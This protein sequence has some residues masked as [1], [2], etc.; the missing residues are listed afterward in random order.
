[1]YM[2]DRWRVGYAAL[3]LA[4]VLAGCG[5]SQSGQQGATAN[6]S[7]G[8]TDSAAASVAASEAPAGTTPPEESPR[9]DISP[10]ASVAPDASSSASDSPTVAPAGAASAEAQATAA[11]QQPSP[12]TFD[13]QRITLALE[14]AA[15]GLDRPLF[16]THAGDGSGRAFVVEKGGAIRTLAD[17]QL[18]LDISDR[19]NARSSEQGLLGLAFHPR[20]PENGQ[21]FVYYTDR[22]GDE[23]VSR[24]GLAADGR[25]DPA[26]EKIILRQEDPAA[27]HNGGMITFGQDGML[28]IGLGDGGGAND[29]F[30]NGQNR[31]TFLGKLLRID[32]DQGD[33]YAVP[34]DNP[35]VN[36]S[37]TRPEIW[38]Y[39]LRNPWRFSFDR[40]T[41][42]L[43]IADVGQNR[44]EMLHVRSAGQQ[45]GE[46][47]GWPILEGRSCLRGDSCDRTGLTVAVADY[48]HSEG[49]SVTGGYVYRGAQYPAM[50]GAYI[51]GD[52]CSGVIWTL[53]GQG[54]QWQITELLRTDAQIS[55]F[56]EDEAGE[57]YMTDLASGTVYRVTGQPR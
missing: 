13:P 19:V 48:P 47:Y 42:D 36:D 51:F 33:P 27:N 20:F 35:F 15:Q 22:N 2:V 37:G 54:Q 17:K 31:D 28:Y 34:A 56:G 32:V 8:A 53:T 1:M 18:F 43:Y 45:G 12:A 9:P 50:Q 25:G 14:P 41:S 23:V 52:Y 21:F 49:C 24:F 7:P 26:S 10:P 29:Q 30:G 55:S 3:A 5:G 16:V 39:G 46:N 11:G 4:L 6:A 57:L 38:A 44:F 40:A